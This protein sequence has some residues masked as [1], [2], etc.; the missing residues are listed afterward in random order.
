M[1]ACCLLRQD[2]TCEIWEYYVGVISLNIVWV[3]DLQTA[4]LM[5]ESAGTPLQ[6]IVSPLTL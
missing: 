5:Q 1:P 6:V 3:G 2:R 4:D